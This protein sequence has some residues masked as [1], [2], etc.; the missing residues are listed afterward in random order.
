MIEKKE[1]IELM[2]E[3]SYMSE[4]ASNLLAELKKSDFSDV[5]YENTIKRLELLNNNLKLVLLDTEEMRKEVSSKLHD[6]NSNFNF[7]FYKYDR[8]TKQLSKINAHVD[9]YHNFFSKNEF[10]LMSFFA[11]MFI[12]GFGIC[13]VWLKFF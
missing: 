6:I 1:L 12:L 9:K 11:G 5:D 4:S 7:L 3:I 13:F 8:I 2:D 10:I